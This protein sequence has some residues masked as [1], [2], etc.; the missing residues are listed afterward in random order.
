MSYV[1]Y[2]DCTNSSLAIVRDGALAQWL[3][4]Y[5]A[6]IGVRAA[7]RSHDFV[8]CVTGD[9]SNKPIFAFDI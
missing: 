6:D 9:D 8:S 7:M 4:V 5:Y 2:D 1:I 3:L